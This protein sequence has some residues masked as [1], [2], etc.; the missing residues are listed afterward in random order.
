MR[1]CSYLHPFGPHFI[2]ARPRFSCTSTACPCPPPPPI[3]KAQASSHRN[4]ATMESHLLHHYT[5]HCLSPTKQAIDSAHRRRAKLSQ[6]LYVVVDLKKHVW[7]PPTPC[8]LILQMCIDELDLN[9]VQSQNN[10]T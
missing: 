9:R 6:N 2:K 4:Y 7:I 10:H 8:A 1:G 5:G 3:T